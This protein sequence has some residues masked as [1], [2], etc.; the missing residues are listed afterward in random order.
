[1]I[2]IGQYSTEKSV[3]GDVYQST[4]V[5]FLS[6]QENNCK[7]FSFLLS[8]ILNG[9][10]YFFGHDHGQKSLPVFILQMCKKLTDRKVSFT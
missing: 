3:I 6:G 1:M 8:T 9:F 4:S 7:V 5:N 10:V 2:K